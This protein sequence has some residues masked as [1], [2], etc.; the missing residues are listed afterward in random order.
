[1]TGIEQTK[2][3]IF[4]HTDLD[5]VGSPLV[6]KALL[7]SEAE[8]R[9]ELGWEA[10]S[11]SFLEVSHCETGKNGT[12]DREILDFIQSGVKVDLIYIT[13]LCPSITTLLELSQYASEKSIQWKVFDHHKTALEVAEVFP[14]SVKVEVKDDATGYLHSATSV[15]FKHFMGYMPHQYNLDLDY[16]NLSLE[17][18]AEI[19]RC[20][21]CWDW[22]NNPNARYQKEANDLN[23]LFYFFTREDR[24]KI[25]TTLI[26]DGIEEMA[27]FD[28]IIKA[29]N[30][31][32][33]EYIKEKVAGAHF[34]SI[35]D[36]VFAYVH[37]E[38]YVST[39]GNAL[40]NLTDPNGEKVDFGMVIQGM[41]VSL[42]ASEESCCDVSEIVKEYFDGGGHAK[43]A[44]GKFREALYYV[45]NPKYVPEGS[46]EPEE[47]FSTDLL[48][49][50]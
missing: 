6:L 1:M 29:M 33:S 22:K 48:I 37:A 16:L 50:E 18:F 28:P 20:F 42:R 39:L 38:Q 44:G 14:Q 17:K 35:G 34:N 36:H 43:A 30:E 40:A 11:Y 45:N 26:E 10:P 12:I 8:Q 15:I 9:V 24:V 2:V 19:I 49:R 31:K 7:L 3:K 25:L 4:S 21:D 47:M 27:H 5:G 23:N 41:K 13:D 32:E 46:S